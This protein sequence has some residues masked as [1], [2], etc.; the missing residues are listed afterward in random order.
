MAILQIT[1]GFSS[2]FPKMNKTLVDI[3]KYAGGLDIDSELHR[4]V[5]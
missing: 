4:E 2:F 5:F 1:E 3:Y